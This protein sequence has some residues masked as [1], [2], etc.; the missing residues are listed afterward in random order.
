MIKRDNGIPYYQQLAQILAGQIEDGVFQPGSQISTQ[1]EMSKRYKL[2]RHTVRR[3]LE[4]LEGEGLIY[5]IKGKGS[6]VA[7]KIRYRVSR[8]TRFTTSIIDTGLSPDAKLVDSYET[9]AGRNLSQRLNISPQ[10]KVTVLEILRFVDSMPFCHTTSFLPS[11]KFPGL[12]GFLNGS[13]SLYSL[14]KKRYGIEMLRASSV[15]EVALPD[16]AD[17]AL[18]EISHKV[19]LLIVKSISK[20]QKEDIVEYCATK[21]RGDLCSIAVDF[22]NGNGIEFNQR[23]AK[24]I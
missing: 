2:N 9:V 12:Q 21:F 15:F 7:N 8:R 6:F 22:H 19:P 1:I 17:L 24:S 20:S 4:R 14:L 16:S 13:F 23:Q 10:E 3:A 18:L 11:G 5:T